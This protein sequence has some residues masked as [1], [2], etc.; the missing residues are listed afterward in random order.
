MDDEVKHILDDDEQVMEDISPDPKSFMFKSVIGAIF[1]IFIGW[2]F[3]LLGNLGGECEING[4]PAPP[5]QCAAMFEWIGFLI[6]AILPVLMLLYNWLVLKTTSYAVT[7]KR[8]IIKTGF[9]GADIRSLRYEEMKDVFVNVDLIG[10][11]FGSGTISFDLGRATNEGQNPNKSKLLN[12]PKPYD[13]Y[14]TVQ[15]QVSS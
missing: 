12:V 11:L 10:K 13:V 2:I 7:D 3:T 5:E 8:V 14:K 4:E 1:L 9:L 6:Y 15:K